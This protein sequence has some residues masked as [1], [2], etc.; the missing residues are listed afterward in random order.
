MFAFYLRRILL[1]ACTLLSGPFVASTLAAADALVRTVEE[2]FSTDPLNQGWNIF[3]QTNLFHWNP[4][5]KCLAMT[6][7]SSQ[8][9]SYLRLPL[10]T[11]LTRRDDFSVS[12]DLRLHDIVPGADPDYPGTFQ[13]AFGFQNRADAE[14][15]TPHPSRPLH[16]VEPASTVI[17]AP[18]MFRPASLIK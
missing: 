7:D 10:Q 4:A 5:E 18:E 12:L 3:G 14:K 6:W 1:A 13:I 11:L 15:P 8:S 16:A 2:D 17:T 9:N